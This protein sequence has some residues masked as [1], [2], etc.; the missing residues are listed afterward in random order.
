MKRPLSN[1]RLFGPFVHTD[2]Y[3]IFDSLTIELKFKEVEQRNE[4]TKTEAEIESKIRENTQAEFTINSSDSATLII[5]QDPKM[6]KLSLA[7]FWYAI[8][9]VKSSTTNK[10]SGRSSIR[11]RC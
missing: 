5:K 3:A 2:K 11:C 9:V 10:I 7:E 6:E 1:Y 8:D 4:F